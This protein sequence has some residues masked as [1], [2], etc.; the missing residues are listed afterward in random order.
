M[1]DPFVG[2]SSGCVAKLPGQLVEWVS[3][4]QVKVKEGEDFFWHI[5]IFWYEDMCESAIGPE[6]VGADA[7]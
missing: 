5:D 7:H 3:F 2:L 1:C 4:E 6:I